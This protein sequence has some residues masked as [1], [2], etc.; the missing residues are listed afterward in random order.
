MR[1]F[2]SW[3]FY[4]PFALGVAFNRKRELYILTLKQKKLMEKITL[5][6]NLPII[7]NSKLFFFQ[8]YGKRVWIELPFIGIDIKLN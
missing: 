7:D 1:D 8:K 2:P 5:Y 4:I 3:L 6:R